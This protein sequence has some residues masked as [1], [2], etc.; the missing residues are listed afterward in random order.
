MFSIDQNCHS[1]WDVPA[2]LHALAGR[3]HY[4]TH[5]I[6]DIDAAFTSLGSA[7]DADDLR[8]TRERYH[9]S[10]GAD[11][12]AALFYTEF[13]GRM[14]VE[15]RAW[16]PLTGLKTNVLARQLGR[17]VDELY[18]E[19]SPGD[20]WQLVGSS[21]VGDRRH[22][23]VI[24]DLT[25]REAA[26]FVRELLAR[27]RANMLHAFPSAA[28]QRRLTEWFDAE[29]AH[30]RSL[31]DDYADA[32]LT[33]LYEQW[34]ADLLADRA[35]LPVAID[36]TSRLFA[37]DAVRPGA[38]L[39]ADA[40]LAD[41]PAA[42]GL[43]NE[44]IAETHSPLRPLDVRQ[45]EMPFFA[46][47]ARA[48]HLVRTGVAC[49]D[50]RL[51]IDERDFAPAAGG[52]W[53]WDALA[54]AGIRCV[55]GKA[56]VLVS[57]VR[58]ERPLALPYR[59][60]LYMPTAHALARK[61]AEAR[62]LPR[63]GLRPVVRVRLR[64]LDRL[65]S[66]DTPIRPPAHLAA[67][68]GEAELPARRLGESWADIAA[69]ARARLKAFEDDAARQAWQRESF[70]EAVAEIDALDAR[71][72]ELARS[73]PKAPQLREIWQRVRDLQRGLL[74]ATVRQIDR[75][76]QVAEIDY[77]D[78][79]GAILPWCIALGGESFY[80]E[81]IEAAEIYEEHSLADG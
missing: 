31:L 12:G 47:F 40:F 66:V 4:V 33:Q 54:G 18:D 24:G 25:V 59:G 44:A 65:R 13:L 37:C 43:Y 62:I 72:R 67:A 45:G 36:L 57:Q 69:E 5:F 42:A 49:R 10:G 50:G 32:K 20:N 11:W 35:P 46:T 56:L 27:A 23:R 68:L 19:F 74:D 16:E 61:L 58:C 2:K 60:S 48:G 73:D 30:A 39:L 70:P 1:L 77:Y 26:P 38:A 15:L 41:Y 17:S 51:V 9:R 71:R 8:L 63:E 78:S 22:H 34:L 53:P 21:F 81:L 14:P 75:D 7:V 55:A 79:R 3:G 28:S 76:V 6:E 29:D 80:N 64:L 52:T